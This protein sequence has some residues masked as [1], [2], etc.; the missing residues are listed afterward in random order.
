MIAFQSVTASASAATGVHR[1]QAAM[2]GMPRRLLMRF[3]EHVL[4]LGK[5]SPCG[6]PT[7]RR[8]A[9]FASC[10]QVA[11]RLLSPRSVV[12]QDGRGGESVIDGRVHGIRE[13]HSECLVRL[14]H[15]VALD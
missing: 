8:N 15:T 9:S 7:P 3:I 14:P 2:I 10:R 1:A 13:L 5:E 4:S 12:V 6:A 11:R